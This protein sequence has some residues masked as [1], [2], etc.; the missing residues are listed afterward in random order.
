[1]HLQGAT[2]SSFYKVGK[3]KFWAVWLAKVK[4]GDTTFSNNFKKSSN[5]PRNIKVNEFDTLCNFVYEAYGLTKQAPFKTWWT[6]HLISTINVN[7]R[8]LV[9]SP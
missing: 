5:Y 6:D 4:D 8:M 3:A 9:P 7:L 2:V 1:M